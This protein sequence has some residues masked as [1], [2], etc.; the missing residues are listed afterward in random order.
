MKAIMVMFDSLN[1][2]LLQSYGCS[3]TI[4]PNFMRLAEKSVQFDC[5]YAASLP[6]M[7]ARRE[8][9]TGRYNFLHRSWGPMEPF[10]DSMPQL[11]KMN[12]VHS[13]LVSDHGHYWEDGGAT[14]HTRYRT[15]ENFRGQE[16]DPW[17]GV[18]GG[19]EDKNPNLIE[20]G[21]YRGLLYNQDLV[22]RSYLQNEA[23]HP[24]TRTFSAGLDFMERNK[25]ADN[26]FLQIECFDP[27][28]PF[29][30]YDKYKKMYPREYSGR[31]FDWPDYAMVKES[32][33]Q[34]KEAR[35]EYFALLTMCDEHLG[36][37][38]DFMDSNNMWD[39]TM[40]IVNTDHGYML[41]E[42]N[43]WA[44][45]Y[46]PLYEEITHIPLYIWDPRYKVAGEKRKELVQTID[47]PV[48]LLDYFNVPVPKDMLGKDL[49]KVIGGDEAVREAAL[50]G[51]HGAH[52][53]CTDGRYVYM[54]APA[55]PENLPLYEYTLMPTH[56]VGF[57]GDKALKS[58]E[59]SSGVEFTKG[60]PVMRLDSDGNFGGGYSYGDLLFDLKT[61]PHQESPI[62]DE[63]IEERMKNLL[64]KLMKENDAPHEQY[65]R[66]GL[67]Y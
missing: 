31:R 56:M 47:L 52:I 16:G 8:L 15:W 17:K 61:D 13:H 5:C 27:H 37:V 57:F 49:G 11:L 59:K 20:F 24:Q 64:I 4:T 30:S 60:I 7:P 19:V 67:T 51:V 6:C 53:C 63:Q 21:G 14:Y 29:F 38:L 33:E 28:E 42:H 46:M 40:L 45:N 55:K 62:K 9:H 66:L 48:T 18:V 22:N 25:D 36:K 35:Y 12:G 32:D 58:M 50:F 41:G 65:E 26:W 39:D 34:V 54:K 44:K 1:R 43:Y 23:D 3:E 10:D 2:H